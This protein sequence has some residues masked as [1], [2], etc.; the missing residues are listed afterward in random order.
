MVRA[1]SIKFLNKYRS[2]LPGWCSMM[3]VNLSTHSERLSHCS[4]MHTAFSFVPR[5]IFRIT[6]INNI[7]EGNKPLFGFYLDVDELPYS[8][9][10][11]SHAL[12]LLSQGCIL[13]CFEK[14][15]V[16]LNLLIDYV[17]FH[18][19]SSAPTPSFFFNNSLP[20][21]VSSTTTREPR[22]FIRSSLQPTLL[23]ET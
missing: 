13:L 9:R 23:S 15:N 20:S 3:L 8:I 4:L 17:I 21:W 18:L 11:S 14:M 12:S 6:S 19:T 10:R 16:I 2:F 22:P 7:Y 5:S 1:F